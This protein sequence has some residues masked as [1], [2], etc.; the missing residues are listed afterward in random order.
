[1]A[2]RPVPFTIP[3]TATQCLPNAP[4]PCPAN[5][6]FDAC[7]QQNAAN[8]KKLY[9]DPRFAKLTLPVR[10]WSLSEPPF[11]TMPPDAIRLQQ[12]GN[13]ILSSLTANVNNTVLSYTVPFGFEGI[14][15]ENLNIFNISPGGGPEFQ[16]GS[17]ALLWRVIINQYLATYYTAI[18]TSMGSLANS[19]AVMHSG[20]IRIKS[21]QTITYVVVPTTAALAGGL[22]PNGQVI[23]GFRGWIYPMH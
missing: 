17:G 15:N 21:N 20:G 13:L 11:D 5:N 4:P 14:I 2:S 22:D 1:M 23:C 18:N 8:W 6:T 7:L 16:S 9:R 3:T 19:G 12:S 10:Y